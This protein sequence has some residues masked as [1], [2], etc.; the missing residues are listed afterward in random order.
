[1]IGIEDKEGFKI[2]R[3]GGWQDNSAIEETNEVKGEALLYWVITQGQEIK[4]F[5]WVKYAVQ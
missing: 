2:W 1:M 4:A 3:L 5:E